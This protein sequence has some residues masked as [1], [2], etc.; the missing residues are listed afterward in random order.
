MLHCYRHVLE[1]QPNPPAKS[2]MPL[3]AWRNALTGSLILLVPHQEKS[4]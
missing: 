4:N 1:T 3:P 2:Y